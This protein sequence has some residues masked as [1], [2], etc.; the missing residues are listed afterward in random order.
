MIRLLLIAF[1]IFAAN[2]YSQKSSL[3]IPLEVQAAYENGTRTYD[4]TVSNKYW[5]NQTDYKINAELFPDSNLLV[6]DTKIIYNNYSPDSL[7]N[8]VFRLYQNIF[9][10]GSV[11]DWNV[12]DSYLGE[13][14]KI[15][16]LK[17]M[18]NIIDVNS[19]KVSTAGTNLKIA[20]EK[21]LC[22]N[23][24]LEI[25]ISWEFNFSKF[26]MRMG[27]YAGDYFIAYWYPQIAVYDDVNDWDELQ[28]SGTAE[29]YNDFNNY[30]LNF[31]V[32]SNYVV[33]STGD[34]LNSKDVFQNNIIE[35]IIEA[36]KSDK[37]VNIITA[38]DYKN[39]K[40]TNSN[41]SGKNIWKFEA[42]KVPDVAWVASNN[43]NW[44]ASSVEVEEGRR[45]LTAAIY[46]DSIKQYRNSAKY[47]NETIKYM[48]EVS[49]GIPY[50]WSH[51]TA[52]TNKA[53]SGGMEFPMM[54]NNGA[55]KT[56]SGNAGLIF[57]EIS[58]SYLPFYMGTD[59]RRAAWMDEGWASLLSQNI[60]DKYDTS[61]GPKYYERRVSDYVRIAGTLQDMPMILPSYMMTHGESRNNFY[62]RPNVAYEEL[63]QLLGDELFHKALREYMNRWHEKHPI[64]Y[65]FFFTFNE[66]VGEDLSWFW[67]PWFFELGYPDLAIDDI[68]V[69]GENIAISLSK[70]GNIPTR[71]EITIL[72]EDGTF[73]VLNASVSAWKEKSKIEVKHKSNKKIKSVKLGSTTI[74]DV[75]R[76]NNVFVF[77]K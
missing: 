57:H 73:E 19:S 23:E 33:W 4:G 46:P 56:E 44:D 10:P 7:R 66:V 20:L 30:E 16:S 55:P 32:P 71:V 53:K 3:F 64:A 22:P 76:E 68:K 41:S 54:Q 52:F 35:K 12:P 28:Y 14:I 40:V 58:H 63:R 74:P 17:I 75:N 27:N 39:G 62:N 13:G 60:V 25:E 38:L 29:F 72:Y 2:I 24:N 5:I 21:P 59:E 77:S 6:G 69:D 15:T 67:K 50:P 65:D 49:P 1:L 70:V 37:T 31:K 47:A 36:K 8:I 61:S 18:G 48:S 9:K 26:P 42:K 34:L 43:Y 45:V 11:R 51:T